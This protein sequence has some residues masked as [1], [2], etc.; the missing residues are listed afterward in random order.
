MKTIANKTLKALLAAMMVFVF[1]FT[2]FPSAPTPVYASSAPNFTNTWFR[3][4]GR[5]NIRSN[6]NGV[7]DGWFDGT[8]GDV[9]ILSTGHMRSGVEYFRV[10][11]PL[12]A[13]GRRQ[14]FARRTDVI[15]TGAV[16][17]YQA[18]A[19]QNTTV[20]RQ[21]N[22]QSSFG[23]VWGGNRGVGYM[24]VVAVRGN[25]ARIIY[26]LD[27]GGHRMGWVPLS[28][29][30]RVDSTSIAGGWQWPMNNARVTAD[31][32]HRASNPPAANR[33]HHVGIDM[34]STDTRVMAAARGVVVQAG[35]NADN[36]NFVTIRHTLDNGQRVYS[37]YAHLRDSTTHLR[38][39]N[40][41]R[42]QQ[43]GVMGNTGRS[44]GAH[45]HFSISNS[46]GSNGNLVG[47]AAPGSNNR[48]THG[49]VTFFNP[50]FIIQNN[51]LP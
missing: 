27:A 43:I 18:Q 12:F 20:F 46:P 37:F 42:G 1:L 50:R 26:R 47:W 11:Y 35:F 31:W 49:G 22:M 51:R 13:G 16:A 10:C 4:E 5:I 48:A 30:T 38:N 14:G 34:V 33:T 29:I 28:S 36:G 24:F 21:S 15:G 19:R 2:I 40:V 32:Q 41:N 25:N 3:A 6:I 9:R 45:L 39:Q 17:A 23:T 7:H 8:S 44:F